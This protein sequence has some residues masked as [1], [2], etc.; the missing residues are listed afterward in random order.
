M[1]TSD[2]DHCFGSV[3]FLFICT[4]LKKDEPR[5]DTYPYSVLLGSLSNDD[6][7]GNEDGKKQEVYVSKIIS[8]LV[9]NDNNFLFLFLNFDTVL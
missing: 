8:R 7:D 1:R 2:E 6:S 4:Q 5:F 9:E 3:A